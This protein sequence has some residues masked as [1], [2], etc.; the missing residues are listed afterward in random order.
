MSSV[1]VTKGNF[2]LRGTIVVEP[3]NEMVNYVEDQHA[4]GSNKSVTAK[5]YRHI[6]PKTLGGDFVFDQKVANYVRAI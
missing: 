6:G 3:I 1:Q 2:V 5:A 4:G